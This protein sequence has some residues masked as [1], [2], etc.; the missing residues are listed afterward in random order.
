MAHF[1]QT[2]QLLGLPANG[3]TFAGVADMPFQPRTI[4]IALSLAAVATVNA[5][6]N[7][8][9]KG[10]YAQYRNLSGLPASGYGVDSDGK[11]T[12][13]GAF[14]FST[15]V[16]YSLKGG[17]ISI[18]LGNTSWD[19]NFRFF[20]GERED[21]FG[22]KSNGTG[23][24]NFGIDTKVG[25]FTAGMVVVSGAFENAYNVQFTPKQKE[26]PVQFG[27]G[28]QGLFAAGGFIGSGFADNAADRSTSIFGVGTWKANEKTHVSLGIGTSRFHKGFG[29]VSYGFTDGIKG[30]VEY[31]G[32]DWN[33]GAGFNLGSFKLS[34]DRTAKF[35]GTLSMV[36]QK[37]AAWS[38]NISF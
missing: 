14:S 27:L 31:D 23:S 32:I 17:E 33:Y 21:D 38:L 26:G 34:K 1:R 11:I 3:T 37:Y 25:R 35:T 15:P 29:N 30:F 24:F 7:F 8:A 5:Q 2:F 13:K 12:L 9:A 4:A 19:R 18:T 16:A 36:A 22:F 10:E 6:A 20:E 28:V